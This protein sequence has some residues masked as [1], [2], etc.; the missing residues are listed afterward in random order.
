MRT[1]LSQ[2][3]EPSYFSLQIR[4]HKRE[5]CAFSHVQHQQFGLAS[6]R[7]FAGHARPF[8]YMTEVPGQWMSEDFLAMVNWDIQYMLYRLRL[9]PTAF[10]LY[11]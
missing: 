4:H 2:A 10:R 6:Q 8:N 9:S 11:L 7:G 3:H 5:S 1:R